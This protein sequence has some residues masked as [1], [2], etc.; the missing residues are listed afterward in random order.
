MKLRIL[1]CL[2]AFFSTFGVWEASVSELSAQSVIQGPKQKPKP[3]PKP[4]P[5]PAKPNV[6]QQLMN[7]G[8]AQYNRQEYQAA[9]TTFQ[10]ALAKYPAKQ[11][12]VQPWIDKCNLRLAEI[13]QR[14]REV[15]EQRRAREEAARREREESEKKRQILNRLVANMVYV[16]GGTFTMGATKEQKRKARDDEKPAHQVTLSSFYIGKYEVTQAEW[17]AVM[18][19]NPSCLKGANL[20]VESVS[21]YDC[22]EFIRKLNELTGKQ[23]R[24]PTEAE[25]EYAARGGNKSGGYKYAG[26]NDVDNVA[27]YL[28]NSDF[29]T[30]PVGTKRGNELGLYDMSGNVKEW[31]QEWYG[32]YSSDSQTNPTGP[33][34]GSLRV[35]RG[36]SWLDDARYCRLSYRSDFGPDLRYVCNGLRLA[37]PNLQ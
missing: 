24:L 30:H 10:S 11:S 18:G 17:E 32:S 26:G 8:K 16:E 21:W 14:E 35:L 1:L 4:K 19:S 6:Y 25:W 2:F 37:L 7:E 34:T 36:G 15:A 20:P 22:Q 27:W 33:A 23:F 5:R 28:D 12:E 31:C 29:E 9:L 3:K 13:A